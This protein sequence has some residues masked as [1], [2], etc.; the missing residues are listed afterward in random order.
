MCLLF[1]PYSDV[2]LPKSFVIIHVYSPGGTADVRK[3]SLF[4]YVECCVL[5]TVCELSNTMPSMTIGTP[6][7]FQVTTVAALLVEMQISEY[8][9]AW[10]M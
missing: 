2:A 10:L 1:I 6:F 5:I 4:S 3:T 7:L 8:S 9:G